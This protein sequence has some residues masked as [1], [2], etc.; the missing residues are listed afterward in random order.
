MIPT[1]VTRIIWAIAPNADVREAMLGDL[2]EES[3]LRAARD[4]ASAAARWC[5]REAIRS[6][7]GTLRHD[8]PGISEVVT[9]VVPGMLWGCVVANLAALAVIMLTVRLTQLLP[10]SP[11]I[12]LLAILVPVRLGTS[13]MG[14]FEAARVGKKAPLWS[15]AAVGV[16]PTV[17]F[18]ILALTVLSQRMAPGIILSAVLELVLVPFAI[19]GGVLQQA[20]HHP[21]ASAAT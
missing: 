1:G 6:L 16:V 8:V 19:L 5:W 14:G 15:A 7:L 4:G 12:T 18:V 9:G 13:V 17:V 20:Q 21:R 10:F 11:N 3:Q 2:E